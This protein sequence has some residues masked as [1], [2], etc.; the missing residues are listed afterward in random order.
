M[1]SSS[2]PRQPWPRPGARASWA[3][4]TTPSSL[5]T[6]R[7]ATRRLHQPVRARGRRPA[8]SPGDPAAHGFAFRAGGR[9][10]SEHEVAEHQ[11]AGRPAARVVQK[12]A[13]PTWRRRPGIPPVAA[14]AIEGEDTTLAVAPRSGA[15]HGTGAEGRPAGP[16]T[17]ATR[18]S[19]EARLQPQA[20]LPGRDP[21]WQ[22]RSAS[23]SIGGQQVR[24]PARPARASSRGEQPG[25]RGGRHAGRAAR[26]AALR[27]PLDQGAEEVRDARG[28]P[29]TSVNASSGLVDDQ[30]VG[31]G[32]PRRRPVERLSIGRP[33]G[34]DDDDPA[35]VTTD[36]G[37]EPRPDQGGLARAGRPD[38]GE[39]PG[40]RSACDGTASMSGSRPEEPVGVGHVVGAPAPGR[41][42]SALG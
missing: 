5:V 36:P 10:Q 39:H 27:D 22:E 2:H 16:S 34:G 37:R 12:R 40:W 41:G 33:A 28:G 18:S 13:R 7:A 24:A 4:S 31:T 9:T 19:S 20:C 38:D 42:R 3:S 21:R 32:A 14:V 23:S 17:S 29:R 1:S 35:P 6:S 25:P 26:G 8:L 30:H 15:A 11:V